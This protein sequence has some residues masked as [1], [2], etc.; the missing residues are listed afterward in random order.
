M[1]DEMKITPERV[2]ELI[3]V[4]DT[5]DAIVVKIVELIRDTLASLPGRPAQMALMRKLAW[6]LSQL[7]EDLERE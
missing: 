1:A 6:A 5:L 3:E 4:N 2:Q 7:R